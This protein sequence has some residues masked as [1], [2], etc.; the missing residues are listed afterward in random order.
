MIQVN[1]KTDAVVKDVIRKGGK[2][3]GPLNSLTHI[4]AELQ[5]AS[6]TEN[7]IWHQSKSQER[8]GSVQE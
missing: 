8:E 6:S 2:E 5:K 7:L 1:E 3:T 4:K